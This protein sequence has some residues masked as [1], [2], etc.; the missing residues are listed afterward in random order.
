[1]TDERTCP[2]DTTEPVDVRSRETGAV[3]TVARIC[4]ACLSQLPAAWGCTACEWVEAPR[5]LCDSAPT[6]VLARPCQEHA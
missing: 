1:M 3:E 2:H 5:R 6:L 4:T